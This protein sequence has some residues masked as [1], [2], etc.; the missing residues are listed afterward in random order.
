[1]DERQ[2]TNIKEHDR[3][4]ELWRQK[5]EKDP[6][7]TEG[8]TG[9]SSWVTKLPKTAQRA[10]L[11][12]CG[13]VAIT[14]HRAEGLI[15]A[16]LQAGAAALMGKMTTSDPYVKVF[17]D[18]QEYQ[19]RVISKTLN[20]IWE[21]DFEVLVRNP[22]PPTA[23]V[24][25][26]RGDQH[27]EVAVFDSD[28]T[29]AD[30]HL[31]SVFLDVL[32]L[33]PGQ[34]Y[35]GWFRIRGPDDTKQVNALIKAESDIAVLKSKLQQDTVDGTYVVSE[36]FDLHRKHI[37]KGYVLRE[38]FVGKVL[39]LGDLDLVAKKLRRAP[40]PLTFWSPDE[41]GGIQ[42]T[43]KTEVDWTRLRWAMI[44]GIGPT[45]TFLPP[46]D[47]DKLYS[48]GMEMA[49]IM[50]FQF[51]E[52][53][54][55]N[56]LAILTWE[57][58]SQSAQIMFFLLFLAYVMPY[59]PSILMAV[60]AT[61]HLRTKW[62]HAR[63]LKQK[64]AR[65]NLDKMRA[66]AKQNQDGSRI[67]GAIQSAWRSN[68]TKSEESHEG[69]AADGAQGDEDKGDDEKH[70][71]SVL[72]N[73][74]MFTPGISSYKEMARP[75]QD[76]LQF[77]VG[78]LRL[79]QDIFSWRSGLSSYFN[80]F[81]WFNVLL[82]LPFVLPYKWFVKGQIILVFNVLTPG[83]TIMLGSLFWYLG[84]YFS[85]VVRWQWVSK[86]DGGAMPIEWAHPVARPKLEKLR[87]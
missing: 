14:V 4:R 87:T 73:I 52:K 22:N 27:L 86:N 32:S 42:L 24:L 46:F 38:L 44:T 31:G 75:Y 1:M 23:G 11:E 83:F 33:K 28:M 37:P 2:E 50:W 39:D 72:T 20:P 35:S 43:I 63:K 47:L 41:C 64:E 69:P 9:G 34:T 10:W 8:K 74:M 6:A 53:L 61:Q 67:F 7:D 78:K 76:L 45:T 65:K 25:P 3:V 19:T 77:V 48:L 81:L 36:D 17:F 80:M 49:D 79:L 18:S 71:P 58:P 55:T 56:V 59:A 5:V 51:G 40:F 21:E 26:K 70:L 29:S 15:P 12:G 16:D 54:L 13:T 57:K 82:M 85:G 30:D 60:S 68:Q 84:D 62:K 66:A